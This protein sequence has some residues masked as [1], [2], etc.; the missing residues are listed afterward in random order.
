MLIVLAVASEASGAGALGT[1]L[2]FASGCMS[3][4]SSSKSST[5]RLACRGVSSSSEDSLS[6]SQGRGPACA[7]C[8]AGNDE[9]DG[10]NLY[11]MGVR[12]S[13]VLS[14]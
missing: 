14:G 11:N 9:E 3:W 10:E 2:P 1:A 5:V 6:K 4:S 13:G 8:Q 7:I 12:K